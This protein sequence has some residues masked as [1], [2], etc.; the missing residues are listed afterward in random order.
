MISFAEWDIFELQEDAGVF[1]YFS[2]SGL[3]SLS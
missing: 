3:F 2:I 1:F